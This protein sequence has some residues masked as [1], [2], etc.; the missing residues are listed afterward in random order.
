M[1]RNNVFGNVVEYVLSQKNIGWKV[2]TSKLNALC[3]CTNE[4]DI[5]SKWSSTE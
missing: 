1:A 3:F 2:N 4:K 5:K